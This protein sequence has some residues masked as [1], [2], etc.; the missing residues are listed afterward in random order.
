[1]DGGVNGTRTPRLLHTLTT[2]TR[3]RQ[4]RAPSPASQ[5]GV[6]SAEQPAGAWPARHTPRSTHTPTATRPTAMTITSSRAS[7]SSRSSCTTG[8]PASLPPPAPSMLL[9][10]PP[11]RRRG[12]ARSK[13]V[14]TTAWLR[15]E[16]RTTTC[17]ARGCALAY[18][19]GR[20]PPLRAVRCSRSSPLRRRLVRRPVRYLRRLCNGRHAPTSSRTR[21][22]SCAS[23][24][25]AA[26][27]EPHAMPP[28]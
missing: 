16:P 4:I 27:L 13:A 26:V 21:T 19:P 1:M 24:C 14:C 12:A 2:A 11:R 3:P 7:L 15:H 20:P 22:T 18:R 5:P 10:W 17:A 25:A 9:A 6:G 23:R 8:W 28:D